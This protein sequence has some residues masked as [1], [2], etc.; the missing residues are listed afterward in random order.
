[1]GQPSIVTTWPVTELTEALLKA[2]LPEYLVIPEVARKTLDGKV[3]F[4]SQS[5]LRGTGLWNLKVKMLSSSTIDE[6]ETET[7]AVIMSAL[8]VMPEI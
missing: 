4:T 6:L 3:I 1:V 8:S 7:T 5:S 2:F